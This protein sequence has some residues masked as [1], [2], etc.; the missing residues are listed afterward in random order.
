MYLQSLA[1]AFPPHSFTQPESLQILTESGAMDCLRQRSRA[2]LERLVEERT[3]ELR[4]A[5][6]ELVQAA[7]MAALGQMSA[8]L[9]HEINQPL[10]AMRMQLGSLGL[11]LARNDAPAVQTCLARIDGLLT[12]MWPGR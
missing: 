7:K 8:A 9:A 3:A 11:L 5:Q 6:D 2:E 12:R 10:T 1:T 4:Q